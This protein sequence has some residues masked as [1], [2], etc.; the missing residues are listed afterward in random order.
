MDINGLDILRSRKTRQSRGLVW[1]NIANY[2]NSGNTLDSYGDLL[3]RK[4]IPPPP[5]PSKKKPLR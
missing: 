2:P 1:L 4:T 5:S 3:A